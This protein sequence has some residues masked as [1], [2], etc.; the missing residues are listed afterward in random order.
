MAGSSPAMAL[1]EKTEFIHRFRKRAGVR[2]PAC[3]G[4]R[5]IELHC[6]AE[7][8]HRVGRRCTRQLQELW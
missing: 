5:L 3:D 6:H 2:A 1:V 8:F 7:L 4:C